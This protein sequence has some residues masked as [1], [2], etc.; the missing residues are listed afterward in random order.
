MLLLS[1][2]MT[3]RF[4]T[5]DIAVIQ[6]LTDQLADLAAAGSRP[7]VLDQQVVTDGVMNIAA[8]N[9]N[10]TVTVNFYASTDS[11]EDITDDLLSNDKTL[12]GALPVLKDGYAVI[13]TIDAGCIKVSDLCTGPLIHNSSGLHVNIDIGF[14]DKFQRS[15]KNNLRIFQLLP[16]VP[17]K[18]EPI[19]AM[20]SPLVQLVSLTLMA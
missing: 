4:Y 14:E 17:L 12:T 5:L 1:P 3:T 9:A 10:G 16:L 11:A 13:N 15:T 20:A 19:I 18:K 7:I 6:F 2:T 8:V